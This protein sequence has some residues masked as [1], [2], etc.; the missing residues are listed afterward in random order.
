MSAQDATRS[1]RSAASRPTRSKIERAIVWGVIALGVAV[2]AIEGAYYLS[3]KRAHFAIQSELKKA[4]ATDYR[5]TEDK[6]REILGSRTP[7]ISKEVE[8]MEAASERYD[9]YVFEGLLKDRTLCVHYGVAGVAEQPEV[10]EVTSIIPD[11]VL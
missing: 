6:V 4:E 1:T 10:I 7:D 8:V 3:Y 11:E 9:I 2:V 5:I